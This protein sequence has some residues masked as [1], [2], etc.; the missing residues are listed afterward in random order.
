MQIPVSESLRVNRPN[1][2]RGVVGCLVNDDEVNLNDEKNDQKQGNLKRLALLQ[3]H[4][5]IEKEH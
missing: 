2:G 5:R 4:K 1:F 3:E